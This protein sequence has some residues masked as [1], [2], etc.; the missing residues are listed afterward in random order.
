MAALRPRWQLDNRSNDRLLSCLMRGH[1]ISRRE[2]RRIIGMETTS[3][4]APK[5]RR[6][7]LKVLSASTLGSA[8]APSVLPGA[9]KPGAKPMRG[10]FVIGSSP[11]TDADELDLD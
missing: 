7:F 5:G 4:P 6:E 8:L 9:G 2:R 3:V 11:F 10:L 1:L